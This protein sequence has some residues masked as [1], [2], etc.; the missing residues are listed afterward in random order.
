[1][2]NDPAIAR[3]WIA[4][5]TFAPRHQIERGTGLQ[6]W[7]NSRHI[8]LLGD[9]E[10]LHSPFSNDPGSLEIWFNYESYLIG[11]P[12]LE[13]HRLQ[14][15]GTAFV[16]DLGQPY[17][18]FLDMHGK[19]VGVYLPGYDHSA[20]EIRCNVHWMPRKPA[21]AFP[22]SRPMVFV[23]KLPRA[24]RLLPAAASLPR[25]A[26]AT[27]EGV[28]VTV[29]AAR[30]GDFKQ[31]GAGI[32]QHDLTF[33]L[34]IDGGEIANDNVVLPSTLVPD[35]GRAGEFHLGPGYFSL[36]AT[37]A[38]LKALGPPQRQPARYQNSNLDTAMSLTD[39]YGF[40]LLPPGM[41]ITPLVTKE[42]LEAARRGEGMV[43]VAPVNN[44]GKGTDVVR[45]HLDVAPIREARKGVSSHLAPIPFDICV[46]VQ[47]GDE[48]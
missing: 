39:P 31:R 26:R 42:T 25:S 20:H 27:K 29:D 17:H 2:Q 19:I 6:E 8:S 28:T 40:A 45:I 47:T 35:S 21:P 33:H 48:I 32:G 24:T 16:D 1:M 23:I 5:V 14:A 46:P 44:A 7:L 12:E 30:L 18:G 43:W 9:Y 3:V 22:V 15:S 4:G 37:A 11:Q 41:A 10:V 13:C 34:K 36:P 38:M